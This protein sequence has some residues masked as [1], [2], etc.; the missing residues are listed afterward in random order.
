[1]LPVTVYMH[2]AVILVFCPFANIEQF[3]FLKEA[4]AVLSANSFKE[5]MRAIFFFKGSMSTANSFKEKIR[6][7]LC[8]SRIYKGII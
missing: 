1:M 7:I 4:G 3:F 2:G 8:F 5:E 6:A